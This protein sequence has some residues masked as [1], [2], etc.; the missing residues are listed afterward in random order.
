MSSGSSRSATSTAG[1]RSST[2]FGSLPTAVAVDGAA[3]VLVRP[4]SVA[5]GVSGPASSASAEVVTRRFFGHNGSEQDVALGD[6]D[7]V[8]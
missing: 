3:D 6:D 5:I 7:D 4:E 2:S 1:C 8:A